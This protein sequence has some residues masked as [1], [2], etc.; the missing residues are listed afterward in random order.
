MD[1]PQGPQTTMPSPVAHTRLNHHDTRRSV[2][3][4][5]EGINIH[6]NDISYH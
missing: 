6:Y 3:R 4:G 5:D 1:S 2:Q